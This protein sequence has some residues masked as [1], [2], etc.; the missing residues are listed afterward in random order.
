LKQ[1][2]LSP[3]EAARVAWLVDSLDAIKVP[4]ITLILK[5]NCQEEAQI[6]KEENSS[7]PKP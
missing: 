6:E 4:T 3:Q 7:E 2:D 1:P 5:K